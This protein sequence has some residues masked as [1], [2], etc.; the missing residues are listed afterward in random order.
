MKRETELTTP[1]ASE[2]RH[3]H[4]FTRLGFHFLFVGSFAML[5]GAVRGF[6]L[7]LVLA[8]LL[9]GALIMQWRWSSR[10]IEA[11]RIQRRLPPE[12]FAEKSFRVRYLLRNHGWLMPAWM[13]R[14]EDKIQSDDGEQPVKAVCGAGVVSAKTTVTP[15][16]ECTIQRR[17]RYEIGPIS[18]KTS[19]P[20]SL[21]TSLQV[22]DSRETLHVFPKL[23]TLR[24]DWQRRLV[25]QAGGM[26]TTAR[27][28]GSVE[29]DFFGLREWQAGDSPKWIHWRTTARLNEPAVRQFEQQ[30]RFDACVLVDA[31]DAGQNSESVELAISLAATFLVH[32]VGSPSN[33][34]VLAVAGDESEA[35]IGGGS[36]EGKRRMLK[37]LSGVRPTSEPKLAD[38]TRTAIEMVGPSKDLI[39]ISPRPFDLVRLADPELVQM[40]GPWIRRGSFRWIDVATEAN[41]WRIPERPIRSERME[42]L[43]QPLG[44]LP[45][46]EQ[47]EDSPEQVESEKQPV[48]A[49]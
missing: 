16:F 21:L 6:N 36:M 41:Q 39:V 4:R 5:G 13:I 40:M 2:P 24:K 27:R 34:L 23:L 22:T 29:G 46:S 9:I 19:F 37:L 44:P 25:S 35:V 3:K 30:R 42:R 10:S 8:G 26:S 45:Q 47:A 20:F 28:S 33:R 49:V 18:V 48:E 31:F 11:L 1:K 38:A 17:G 14:I 15:D 32:L 12:A 43:D 7:L